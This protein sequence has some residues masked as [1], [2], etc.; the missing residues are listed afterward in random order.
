[1]LRIHE[2]KLDVLEPL[3]HL[4]DCIEKKLGCKDL[5]LKSWNVIKESLDARDKGS[6]KRVYSIDFE[7]AS[8]D[9]KVIE[10]EKELQKIEE[11]LLKRNRKIKMDIVIPKS[12]EYPLPR[13]SAESMQKSKE[14]K[15]NGNDLRPLI[16]GFGPCGMFC[17]LLLAQMGLQPL[18]LERGKEMEERTKDVERFWKTGELDVHSNVQFGEGGAGAFSD[19]KLTTQIKDPRVRK[20][21]EELVAAGS[22]KDI[23]YKQKPHIGTDVL[24]NVVVNI[25]KQIIELGGEIRFESQVT[26]LEL[27]N[28]KMK[29]VYINHKEFIPAEF[30]V[31]AL[32]H[33]ARDTVKMLYESGVEIVQK[34]FSMGVRIEHP[35]SMI[36]ESQ[37]GKRYREY[38]LGA[39]DYKI[40]HRCSSG[41]GVYTFCM[42]PGG[43]VIAAASEE[44]GVVTNGMSYHSRD[45]E[46]ANSGLLVDVRTEDF[47]SDHPLAGIHFQQKYEK[48][49]FELGG[50]NYHAPAQRVGDFMKDCVSFE[51]TSHSMYKVQ[52]SY[53][54][55]IV[56]EN[57][58]DC[59]PEF[60]TESIKEALPFLGKKMKG[61]DCEDAVMTALESRSSSPVRIVRGKDCTCN[62]KG[63]YPGGEGAGYAGGIVSAAVDGIKIAEE[64]ALVYKNRIAYKER[65]N[66]NGN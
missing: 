34:P 35:Q 39:A 48:L 64:I 28:K 16:V 14:R 15:E 51:E 55:G 49:T 33:S 22:D 57:L 8:F 43:L 12:Y 59:L 47:A 29:G 3:S 38:H 21:L 52:P 24:R 45:L 60:V 2:I 23:L 25:R 40:S 41:R 11:V 9:N 62:I 32:G 13:I 65:R 46:N 26:S 61:F 37:Y 10:T 30:V 63:V 36:D 27:E 20:V 53:K 31:L 4:P 1:M 66:E 42:C 19:G 56:W 58:K 7:I 6:I 5:K 44:G 54:P 18:V 17:A 50:C